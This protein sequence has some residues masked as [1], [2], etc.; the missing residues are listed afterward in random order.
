MGIWGRVDAKE[1]LKKAKEL[2]PHFYQNGEGILGSFALVEGTFTQLLKRPEDRYL[3]DEKKVATWKL[4]LVSTTKDAVIGILDYYEGIA[5]LTSYSVLNSEEVL[6][7][8]EL[9][10]DEMEKIVSC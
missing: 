5:R 10:Y 8:R 9:T 2:K 1:Q 6:L 3:I 4:V 7:V